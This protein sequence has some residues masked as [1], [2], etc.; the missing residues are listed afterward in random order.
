MMLG[1]Y[2]CYP[3]DI[4]V[5]VRCFSGEDCSAVIAWHYTC[6]PSGNEKCLIYLHNW[7]VILFAVAKLCCR[8]SGLVQ[9][10]ETGSHIMRVYNSHANNS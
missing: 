6:S 8:F 7:S 5:S 9:L 2:G 10:E 3:R 1:T 4:F